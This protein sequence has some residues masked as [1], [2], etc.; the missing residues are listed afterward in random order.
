MLALLGTMTLGGLWH[1]A[2]WQFI[3][4]GLLHGAMLVINHLWR[5]L[6]KRSTVLT[7]ITRNFLYRACMVV[8]T[9]AAL[10]VTW[11]FFRADSVET[12]MRIIR[13][14]MGLNDVRSVTSLTKGIVLG[15]PLYFAFVWF[16]P[17]TIQM[18]RRFP[19]ALRRQEFSEYLRLSG[20]W[21]LLQFRFN[22][23]WALFSM[24]LFLAGWFSLSNLSP[25]IY[26]QF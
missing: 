5:T 8:V 22:L 13:G 1:G 7:S 3:I 11:V 19:V 18:T 9:F 6:T 14:M 21:R 24:V 2:G 15:F 4:W 10:A 23:F 25:F 12:A 16:L 17:N 20:K 26:F